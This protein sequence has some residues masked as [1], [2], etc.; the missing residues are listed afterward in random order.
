LITAKACKLFSDGLH[1]GAAAKTYSPAFRDAQVQEV[2][3][4]VVTAAAHGKLPEEVA[5]NED[6]C[7][8]RETQ[9]DLHEGGQV[10]AEGLG[11]GGGHR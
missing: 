4:A 2:V 3:H 8:D 9:D 5:D 1:R 7:G 6:D 11:F 10:G